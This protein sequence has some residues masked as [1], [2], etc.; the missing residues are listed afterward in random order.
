M[1]QINFIMTVNALGFSRVF[2]MSA[3]PVTHSST[4]V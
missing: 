3:S 4:S 1:M 2:G